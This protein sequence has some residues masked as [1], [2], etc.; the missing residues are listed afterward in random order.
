MHVESRHAPNFTVVRCHLQ[1]E[2][3]VKVGSGAMYA[4]SHGVRL[5]SGVD[6]GLMKGVRRKFLG[7]QSFFITTYTAP[8][9]GG[10]IDVAAKLPGDVA[11]IRVAPD[12]PFFLT[13]GS[14]LAHEANVTFDTTWGGMKNLSGPEGS[15]V[16]RTEGKGR[17][18]L[19]AYGAIDTV[20]LAT[21]ERITVD[22]GHVLAY[23]GTV[24]FRM[25]EAVEGNV[26][27]SFFSG[28]G[29]VFD[30]TGP[31]QLILQSRNPQALVDWIK[32]KLPAPR[33]SEHS[34]PERSGLN[35]KINGRTPPFM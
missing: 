15:F 35:V 7:G 18:V 2:E 16:L 19:G 27:Q 4:T 3:Q 33:S 21:G 28:E 14:C 12:N 11:T 24:S 10:W 13:A 8:A 34:R 22:S 26:I 17:V 25:R 29:I 30:F 5:D 31:G 20:E 9:D 6:G 23:D 32:R 1:P